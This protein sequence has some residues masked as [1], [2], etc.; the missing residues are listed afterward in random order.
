MAASTKTDPKSARAAT[1]LTQDLSALAGKPGSDDLCRTFDVVIIGSGYGA[2]VSTYH[3]SKCKNSQGEP[4]KICVLERGLEYLAGSFPKDASELPGHVRVSTPSSNQATG[5]MEGLFDVRVNSDVSSL[6]ANGF[7]G[8][9]LINAGV[10][11]EPLPKVTARWPITSKLPFK[12]TKGLLGPIQL[13]KS[14]LPRKYDELKKLAPNTKPAEI[15]V[16]EDCNSCGNCATGCNF[17]HKASLDRTLFEQAKAF[18]NDIKF[19][20]GATVDRFEQ[21]LDNDYLWQ[22]HVLPTRSDVRSRTEHPYLIKSRQLIVAAGTF[23]S[24]ELLM[25]SE[26]DQ[27]QFSNKLGQ[28]FSSNGDMLA[29]GFHRD[30]EVNAISRSALSGRGSKKDVGPTI[31]GVADFRASDGILLQEMHVP[32]PIANFFDEIFTTSATI[33][34]TAQWDKTVH[35]PEDKNDPFSL[36]ET[37]LKQTSV[38]AM[39]SDDGAEGEILRPGPEQ[40]GDGMVA[41]KWPK[42][43]Q[44]PVFPHQIEFLTE[45]SK[46]VGGTVIANPLWHP[47]PEAVSFLAEG[48]E[49][50]LMTVHPLGGCPM[51]EC[52]Q[53]GVVN[54]YG[55]VFDR[56]SSTNTSTFSGLTVLDG[57]IIPSALGANPALTISTVA[58]R[59]VQHLAEKWDYTFS[60]QAPVPRQTWPVF[61]KIDAINT[62][63]PKPKKTKVGLVERMTGDLKLGKNTYIIELTMRSEATELRSLA[64]PSF[65]NRMFKL[66]PK[67]TLRMFRKC[68]YDREMMARPGRRR[69]EDR[70]DQVAVAQYEIDGELTLFPRSYSRPKHRIWEGLKGFVCN[71][72]VRDIW[73]YLFDKDKSE[74]QVTESTAKKES[75]KGF[76]SIVKILLKAMSHAGEIRTMNYD[77]QVTKVIKESDVFRFQK[78]QIIGQKTITYRHAANPLRQ[79]SEMTLDCLGDMEFLENKPVLTLRPEFLARQGVPL[80][81]VVEQDNA[82]DMLLDFMALGGY[83]ARMLF[84]IHAATFRLPD[85]YQ[86]PP[87]SRIPSRLPGVE[88]FEQIRLHDKDNKP[89][90]ALLTRYKVA[91]GKPLLLF[92][93]YSASGTTFAHEALPEPFARYMVNQ[94]YD[95]WILDARSS[96]GLHTAQEPW[97]FEEVGTQDFPAAIQHV[98]RETGQQ[99]NVVAHC[100][101]AAM[102]SMAVLRDN[103]EI[104]NLIHRAVLTQVGPGVV[105]SPGNVFRAYMLRYLKQFLKLERFD[106][107][108][109]SSG[110]GDQLIDRLLNVLPYSDE[111]FKKENPAWPPWKRTPW[112]GIRHRMD[113]LWG[114]TF[115]LANM[116]DKVLANLDSQFGTLNLETLSQVIPLSKW[117]NITNAE[118]KNEFFQYRLFKEHWRFPT[119]SL[120]TQENGLWNPSSKTRNEKVFQYLS[121]HFEAKLVKDFG[122]QDIWLS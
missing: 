32:Y 96:S 28:G 33:T 107:R 121:C 34:K 2:A 83:L 101:G 43:K 14:K 35:S 87:L 44:A 10:M 76:L 109:N 18:N 88:N 23:G 27:L 67:S 41:V 4:L 119:M 77:L 94:G 120:H 93:G 70:L 45:Q 12:E 64:D 62:D 46:N 90:P 11:I 54:E 50:P 98:F 110:L 48:T 63:E 30:V 56:S 122:H 25:K 69:F 61:R 13:S 42:L 31:T 15:T 91:N 40:T 117:M 73:Q 65:K 9:S 116:P 114:E 59:A 17:G 72:G 81:H 97:K 108:V 68:D 66:G 75:D 58:Y 105:V 29:I 100:V 16:F 60:D 7:G 52:V 99:V 5:K 80:L 38:Y 22:S 78:P 86:K 111:D 113:V 71:R 49:G 84:S 118:G 79:M 1:Y 51:S 21:I 37:A 8:G 95:V 3:L 26:S 20:T 55:E 6:I 57:A 89:L 82:V 92:H 39:M 85:T 106:F 53:T 103:N 104:T 112:V 102:F 47:L 115:R 19:I 24:T 74:P 36:N